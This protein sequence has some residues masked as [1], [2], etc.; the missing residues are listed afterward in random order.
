[1]VLCLPA[2]LALLARKRDQA[3]RGSI[4]PAALAFCAMALL[5]ALPDI[6]Y[7]WRWFGGPFATQST[8]LHLMR[9]Q[10][11]GPVAWEMLRS[12]LVAG[13][14]GYLFPF[15]L[16]GGWRLARDH[17][18]ATLVLVTAV[19]AVLVVHFTYSALRL[20]DLISLFPLLNLAVAYGI[21]QIAHR[22]RSLLPEDSFDP[23]L[24]EHLIPAATVAA[25]ILSLAL[26][27]WA[28]IDNLWKPGWASFGYMTAQQRA[29][30]DRLD[31]LLP[32]DAVV[33]ASLNAGA[34][35]L[36]TRRAIIRPYEGW[37]EGQWAVFLEAMTASGRSVY[38]LDDGRL[39]SDFIATQKADHLTPIEALPIPLFFAQERDT[40]WL[41]RLEGEP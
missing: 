39:M 33:A 26:A 21:V 7:R 11:I 4:M 1:L 28:M 32:A 27:R 24:A 10:H 25:I 2:S 41:Y 31:V 19:A 35:T 34:V 38:L 6:L 3:A 13:E 16:Y 22:A 14:W 15:A 29:A 5:G 12:A 9:L 36:Y 18:R 17:G 30:F 8:E 37:H 20:R 40:G 23:R